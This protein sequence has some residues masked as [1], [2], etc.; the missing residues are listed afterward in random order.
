M[1]LIVLPTLGLTHLLY[2]KVYFLLRATRRKKVD[3]SR[4]SER[5]KQEY[6][7]AR[8]FL[9]GAGILGGIE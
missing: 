2:D 1:N 4:R 8:K 5:A 7:E 6:Y 3:P 9:I